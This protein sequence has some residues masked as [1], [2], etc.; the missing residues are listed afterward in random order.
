MV[1]SG[2]IRHDPAVRRTVA[3]G[4][5]GGILTITRRRRR[6]FV[7][8]AATLLV[9]PALLAV[10]APAAGAGSS[11]SLTVKAGEYTY[12]LSGKP[13]AG[14]VTVNFDNTGIEDHMMAVVKLK[15]GV[16]AKQLKAAALSEDESAFAKIAQGDGQVYGTPELL[17]PG[18]ETTTITK[19]AGGHYGVLCFVPAPDG[20]PHVAHGMAKVFDIATGKSGAKPPQDGV[21][22]VTVSDTAITIPSNGIPRNGTL[23]VTNEGSAPHSFVLIRIESGKT[24]DAVYGYYTTFFET[25]KTEGTR[26]GVIVGGVATLAP[27]GMAYLDVSLEPGHYGYLSGEGDTPDDDYSKGLEGEFDVT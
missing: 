26:P 7:A 4:P 20:S 19:L 23:K 13:Q 12:K 15:K 9:V 1:R 14:W 16:T 22:D 2:S 5:K 8:A 6:S 3:T 25:G 27:S 11:N 17:S 24:F 18:Q 10:S 21:R